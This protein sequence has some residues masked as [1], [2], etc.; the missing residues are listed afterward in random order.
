MKR[1]AACDACRSLAPLKCMRCWEG[2]VAEY[3][4]SLI[5]SARIVELRCDF[6]VGGDGGKRCTRE[7]GHR[8]GCQ[9]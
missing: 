1:N 6:V 5:D 4:A 9:G 8:G 7:A 2:G 3:L